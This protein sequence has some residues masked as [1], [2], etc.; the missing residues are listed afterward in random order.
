MKCI[1]EKVSQQRKK[2]FF[3]TIIFFQNIATC[4]QSVEFEI[5]T[6]KCFIAMLFLSTP[7]SYKYFLFIFFYF[8][9][10]T[11]KWHMICT[12]NQNTLGNSIFDFIFNMI[13]R[14]FNQ[15]IILCMSKKAYLVVFTLNLFISL[16]FQYFPGIGLR[17]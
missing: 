14:R 1:N 6:K 8:A 17:W 3:E 7:N 13:S 11:S 4:N 9:N 16:A 5:Y 10:F 15:V 2:E 12:K